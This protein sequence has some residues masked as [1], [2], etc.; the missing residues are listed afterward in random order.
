[1]LNLIRLRVA[2]LLLKVLAITWQAKS[3]KSLRCQ[4]LLSPSLQVKH[5]PGCRAAPFLFVPR[6][7]GVA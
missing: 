2:A 7:S 1:M 5:V 3:A 6:R 4:I